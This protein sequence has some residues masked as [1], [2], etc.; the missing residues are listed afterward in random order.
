MNGIKPKLLIFINTLQSGGAERVVSLL[1]G[2]LKDE[3]EIHLA[4][5]SNIIEFEI[6][7]EIKMLNLQEPLVQDKTIRFLKLPY[8]SWKVY[9][10]CKKN[11]INI[12]VAF[13]YRP[14]YINALMKSLWGYKGHVIMCERTHQTTMQQSQSAIYRMFSKFMVM[15]SYKRADLVL[16]NSYAMRTDLIEN[17]KIKTPVKVIYNP[18]DL[19]FIKTHI[20]EEPDFIFEKN[21]FHF[22]NVGGFRKEKNHL[23]LIQAFFILKNLPCK[24]LIV[25]SG[26]MEDEL[27]QKVSDLG[28][29]DKIIFFGF[30]KNPF[31]YVSRSNCFVLSSDVEGFPNVLIEALACGKPV[32][33]TDC[34]S[35]P[36]ELL[37]PAT[38]LHHRA[39]NNYEVGEYG[40]LTP[41]N[42]V[43]ALAAAMKKMY[44]DE[45]LRNQFSEKA[46]KRAE[47]F[48]V[49]E[50]KQYFHVA[51]AGL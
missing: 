14:C 33:S 38:D 23:L 16:A 50:I 45:V 13:L 49:N 27:K 9:R 28:L 15:F 5:Y 21:C 24:L 25:G 26:V 44:E 20:D 1:L 11:S 40:I 31:K 34:S 4:L 36:R 47:Q 12:S 8:I 43:I 18:I 42:D 10:Y 32:I 39:I 6:P 7:P 41:V 22:I 35:G 46:A 2:Y 48:D 17:F 3:F 37:A 29:S 51:F 19:N 30:D